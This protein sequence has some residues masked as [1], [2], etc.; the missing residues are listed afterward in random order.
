MARFRKKPGEIE[1]V[2][3]DG[4]NWIVISDWV[5]SIPGGDGSTLGFRLLIEPQYD[6][7]AQVWDKLHSTWVGVKI[8][9]WI[10]KGVKGEFYPCDKNVFQETYERI[11]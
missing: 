9:D 5:G 1:A 8:G 6:I 2:Q 3:Y 11:D 10:I 4:E 7:D